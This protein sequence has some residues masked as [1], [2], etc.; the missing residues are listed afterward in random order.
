M[1]NKDKC[2]YLP[3]GNAGPVR[4]SDGSKVP[5]KEEVKYLGCMLNSQ[6]NPSREVAY[7]ITDCTLILNRLHF[8]W[9]HGDS[10]VKRNIIVY[11]VVIRAKRIYGFET[12]DINTIIINN[13]T[14]SNRGLGNCLNCQQ[15]YLKNI[16]CTQTNTY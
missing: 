11:N 4:F 16:E 12:I 7:R 3:F 9:R 14:H 10:K 6:G 2:E 13:Y 5:K 1:L 8:F 15:G